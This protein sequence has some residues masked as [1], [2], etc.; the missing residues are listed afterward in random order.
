MASSIKKLLQ[1]DGQFTPGAYFLIMTLFAVV[2][3]LVGLEARPLKGAD[4]P[5]VAGVAAEMLLHGNWLEPRLNGQPFLEK[6]PLYYW[7]SATS[8]RV[9]GFNQFAAKLPSAIAAII[10]VLAL[11]KLAQTMGFSPL[12]A[13]LS[14]VM[15]ATSAQYWSNGRESLYDMMLAMFILLAMWMFFEL[16]KTENKPQRKW[17]WYAGFV[18]TLSG[19]VFTKG[20]VGLAL[21]ASALFFWLLIDDFFLTRKFNFKRWFLLFSG[22]ALCFAPLVLWLVPLYYESGYDAV[23]TVVWTNNFGRFTGEHAEHIT[24]FYY[25]L[26]KLGEQFQPWTALLPFAL[27]FHFRRFVKEKDRVSL[28]ILCWLLIPYLL[29]T[30]S[31]GKRQ[32]YVLPLYAAEALLA[33]TLTAALLEGGIKLPNKVNLALV[34]MVGT[35]IL[36]YA[37]AVAGMVFLIM[38]LYFNSGIFACLITVLITSAGILVLYWHRTKKVAAYM[39]LLFG[40]ATVYVAIDMVA[41]TAYCQKQTFQPL[42]EYCR[43]QLDAGKQIC[44]G[45]V[46]E[47]V[48]GAA[49]FYLRQH[50]PSA[51]T[52]ASGMVILTE[53]NLSSDKRVQLVRIFKVKRDKY[54][55]FKKL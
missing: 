46:R 36:G 10:G 38:A 44:F 14:G 52:A 6:Q 49:M 17:L 54:Y 37:L 50:L 3:F 45:Q 33:G 15:L 40:L 48:S 30:L 47:R 1:P 34:K 7:A 4:E 11:F 5:R 31:A 24:P 27:F 43:E 32:V 12:A 20:L 18:L 9:F 16:C 42:F 53:K 26:T 13:L 51:E 23:Y 8:M 35:L 41:L 22:A 25:Y 19:A 39:A 28:F 2:V 29:L 55:F 21:P